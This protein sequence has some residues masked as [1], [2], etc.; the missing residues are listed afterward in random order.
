MTSTFAL[1]ATQVEND[2]EEDGI[3]LH[4]DRDIRLNLA[5]KWHEDLK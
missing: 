4:E 2:E 1:A 3:D 5:K